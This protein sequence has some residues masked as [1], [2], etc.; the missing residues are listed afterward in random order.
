MRTIANSKILMLG[1][2]PKATT[3]QNNREKLNFKDNTARTHAYLALAWQISSLAFGSM[4][5]GS[6]DYYA[7]ALVLLAG[8]I[9]GIGQSLS[10]LTKIHP[11]KIFSWF[12]SA[13]GLAGYISA[14]GALVSF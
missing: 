6:G 10:I 3:L 7:G 4:L 1:V 14:Y 13:I 2:F 11:S 5:M 9:V 12:L 8:L